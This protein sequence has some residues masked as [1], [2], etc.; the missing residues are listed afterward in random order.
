MYKRVKTHKGMVNT[1]GVEYEPVATLSD[2]HGGL[3]HIV[4]DDHC[5]VCYIHSNELDGFVATH[6][7]FPELH[8]ALCSLP[9]LNEV[10]Q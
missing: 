6:Y 3:V 4:E 2:K 10:T 8:E 1:H 9:A 7:I 5:Y